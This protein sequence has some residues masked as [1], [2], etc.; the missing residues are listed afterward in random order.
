[1]S[2]DSRRLIV[3]GT[4]SFGRRLMTIEWRKGR[5]VADKADGVPDSLNPENVLADLVLIYWPEAVLAGAV[6]GAPVVAEPGG[7]RIGDAISVRRSD[8]PWSGTARLVNASF[9]YEIEVRSVEVAP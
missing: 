7:R 8:D 1:M 4:D 6:H 5:V 2:V 3:V 9:G